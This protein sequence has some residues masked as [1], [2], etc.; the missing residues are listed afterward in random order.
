MIANGLILGQLFYI[1]PSILLYMVEI[2]VMF[3]GIHRFKFRNS[4]FNKIFAIYGINNII[5]DLLYYFFFRMSSAP[6]FFGLF[7][8]LS[9]SHAILVFFWYTLFHVSMVTN[10]LDIVLSFNRLTAVLIPVGY[11]RFWNDKIKW[12]VSFTIIFPFICFWT[13]PLQEATLAYFNASEA[14]NMSPEKVSP[15]KWISPTNT[16]GLCV[17][18]SCIGCLICNTYVGFKLYRWKDNTVDANYKQDKLYFVFIMCVFVNQILSCSTEV[19]LRCLK[20]Y[21]EGFLVDAEPC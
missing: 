2:Y 5:A 4:S 8:R 17:A 7:E 21:E 13:I 1:I 11:K 20:I 19:I 16:L 6:I 3:F 10:L 15:V 9:G 14:Y 18:I 12:I